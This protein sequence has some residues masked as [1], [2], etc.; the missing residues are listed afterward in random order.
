M[1]KDYVARPHFSL[2]DR[3]SRW[4]MVM[5]RLKPGATLSQA[6]ANIAAIAASE[7]TIPTI[8]AVRYEGWC[9]HAWSGALTYISRVG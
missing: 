7:N 2:T 4:L 1:M 6:Q 9:C 5:G 8:R 3:G